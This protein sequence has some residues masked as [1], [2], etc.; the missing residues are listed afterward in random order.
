MALAQLSA[1]EIKHAKPGVLY[2]GGSLEFHVEDG[3]ARAVFRYVSPAGQRRSMGPGALD[4][5]ST[6]AAGRS[7]AEA[8]RQA[9]EAR[10]LLARGLDPIDD[11]KSQRQQARA[12]AATKK[13][14]AAQE[15]A[16]LARVA[17]Y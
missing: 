16:T 1:L 9:Q 17:R 2:D 15:Q 4:G 8:R 10:S 13:A 7:L 3:G 6:Q 14:A 11:R 5:T 12:A